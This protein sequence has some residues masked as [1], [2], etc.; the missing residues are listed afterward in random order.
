VDF[1]TDVTSA[2]LQRALQGIGTQQKA[3]AANIANAQT[4]GYQAQRVNFTNSLS[5]AMSS[6]VDPSSAE[7]SSYG[8]DD[9]ES[10]SNNNVNMA[11]EVTDLQ[12]QGLQYQAVAQAISFKY[13][14]LRSAIGG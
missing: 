10:A 11:S 3:T 7:F 4:P 12:T 2:G 9:P 8:T 14:L 6:G 1:L 5:A 13:S